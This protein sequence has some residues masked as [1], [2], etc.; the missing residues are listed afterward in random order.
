LGWRE[1]KLEV[2][3]MPFIENDQVLSFFL[4]DTQLSFTNI[5]EKRF[6]RIEPH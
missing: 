6:G 4:V 1:P 5:S 2:S 3:A